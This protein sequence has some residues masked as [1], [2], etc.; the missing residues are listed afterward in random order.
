MVVPRVGVMV[1]FMI[2][3]DVPVGAGRRGKAGI[4]ARM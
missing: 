2:I 1:V 3:M 4:L